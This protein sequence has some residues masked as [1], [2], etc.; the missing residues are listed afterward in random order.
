[1]LGTFDY[2]RARSVEEAC[3]LLAKDPEAA[4]IL[5]GGTDLLVELRNRLRAPNLLIDIK[6][7]DS[8]MLFEASP[9]G[10]TRIGACVPLNVIAENRSIRARYPAL[11]DAAV[12]I[13]TYQLRNRGT[14][15]GNL[16]NASPAADGAPPLL[17][18]GAEL[19]I[20]SPADAGVGRRLPVAELFAGVKRTT[21]QAGELITGIRIPDHGSDLR[22]AFLKQ[23]RI[24]GHDLAVVNVAGSFDPG[25]GILRIAI[26]SCS[27]TP[28]L[29]DP[30]DAS[31]GRLSEVLERTMVAA[32]TATSPISDVRASAAYRTAVLPVLIRRLL[33]RLLMDEGGV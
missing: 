22:T 33:E 29:L 26:G 19:D 6:G 7:I 2:V 14:L 11:A 24:K 4:S 1:M 25:T 3:H 17:V 16:C 28:A 9:S 8:L 30:I 18:L 13:G 31:R 32:R 12:S 15:G 27:P 23:Q 20:A 5:A 21:L 10:E